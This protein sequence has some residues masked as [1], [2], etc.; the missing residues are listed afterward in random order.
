MIS[1]AANQAP[2]LDWE[3]T[4][5]H[6][7]NGNPQRLK[8]FL[9]SGDVLVN[10][11]G[12]GTLGRV[13]YFSAGP[14]DLPCVADGHI[15][16]ARADGKLADSRYMYYWLNSR[17]FYEYI[18]SALIVGATNQI[19]LNG[20]RLAAAPTALPPLDEQ[21]RIAAFLDAETAR[22][23]ELCA[24]QRRVRDAILARLRAHL[25]V[26]TD[27]L[28][29]SH[30]TLPFRRMIR[31]IEQGVSPQCDNFPADVGSWGVL[32]VSAVKNGSFLESENKSLPPGIDPERRYE[33]KTGDLLITRANTPQLV[34]AAAVAQAPRAK[35]L[36]CDK[37]F[38]VALTPDL[39]NEF[40]VL[41]SLSTRVR[42]MCA[43]AS[44]GTS[45][46][47]ANLKTEEIKRWPIPRAP[48]AAQE[49]AIAELSE[50]RDHAT[51][52]TGAIDRHLPSSPN[53]AKP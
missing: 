11:T 28:A 26:T 52:L 7:H 44:H 39:L 36:L 41:V 27:G 15:T 4:R 17:P 35:L 2:G 16:V 48:L 10:S 33:V 37:I 43:G 23:D 21:R 12:T 38:R 53:A 3:R 24:L 50:A 20:E 32:K 30:G 1:Q 18:Y 31:S 51:Q 45:Q 29:A 40:L 13:G 22:V 34:G 19:E 46:S 14:D 5:L 25:D 42:A 8:G 9:V 47:M 49:N 6:S